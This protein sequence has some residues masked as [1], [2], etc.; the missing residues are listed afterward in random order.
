MEQKIRFT[1]FIFTYVLDNTF[2]QS[3]RPDTTGRCWG[4]D[5]EKEEKKLDENLPL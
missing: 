1:H 3:E 2:G 4:E 5:M